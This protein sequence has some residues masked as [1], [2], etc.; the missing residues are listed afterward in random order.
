[1]VKMKTV[2]WVATNPEDTH[3]HTHHHEKLRYHF[4]ND[5]FA[6]QWFGQELCL[7]KTHVFSSS[8]K[9]K[10]FINRD[11]LTFCFNCN[12]GTGSMLTVNVTMDL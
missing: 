10:L 6:G 5:Q 4:V 9:K 11:I 2:F 8:I 12:E 1:M 3:F 7:S